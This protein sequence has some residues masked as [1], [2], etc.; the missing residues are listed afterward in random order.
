[1]A[2][3]NPVVDLLNAGRARELS[4][5][6]QYMTNHYELE[7][8]GV[9]KLASELKAIGIQEMK[10]AEKLAERILFLGGVP[11]NKPDLIA[12]K[13]LDI[14]GLLKQGVKLEA[15]A[16]KMYNASANACAKAGD[17]ISKQVFEA[18]L[19]DEE[20]H[21]DSF[22]NTLDHVQKLGAAYIATL[23]G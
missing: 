6:T 2:K 18:L 15:E 13:G 8:Q 21:L 10:H 9:E 14:P 17:Q 7:D 12:K 4:A 16:C 23:I 1:M 3:A 22:E 20:E 19:A 5:I 11:T